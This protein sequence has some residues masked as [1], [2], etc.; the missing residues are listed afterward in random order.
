MVKL[1]VIKVK[2]MTN[3]ILKPEELQRNMPKH[4]LNFGLWLTRCLASRQERELAARARD[5]DFVP[6]SHVTVHNFGT[7]VPRI[8]SPL[9]PPQICY[10]HAP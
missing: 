2:L 7:S 8:P 5:T 6:S 4:D 1:N 9:W 10:A 3:F